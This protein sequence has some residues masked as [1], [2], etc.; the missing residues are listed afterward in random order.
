MRELLLQEFIIIPRKTSQTPDSVFRGEFSANIVQNFLIIFRKVDQPYTHDDQREQSEGVY[1]SNEIYG[2]NVWSPALCEQMGEVK[3]TEDRC[4]VFPNTN[5]HCV[6][7]FNLDDP[8]KPGSRKILVF[9]L[10]DPFVRVRSTAR[11]PPQ[12]RDW[13]LD[14]IQTQDPNNVPEDIKVLEDLKMSREDANKYR[15]QLMQERGFV[16]TEV[17]GAIFER[18]FNLCEH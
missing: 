15:A 6:H 2:L 3:T 12:Q 10:V 11:V 4:I 8:T 14:H 13:L 17:N 9:F 18:E 7:P 16:T 5:Q 1:E